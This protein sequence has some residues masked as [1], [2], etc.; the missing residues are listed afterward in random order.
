[1][2]LCGLV[3]ESRRRALEMVFPS[4]LLST[5][6]PVCR[7]ILRRCMISLFQVSQCTESNSCGSYHYCNHCWNGTV[8][9]YTY[10]A[11]REEFR[12]SIPRRSREESMVGGQSTYIPSKGKHRWCYPGYLC[13]SHC[14]RRRLSLHSLL[15]KGNG[16]GIGSKIL[17][18]MI[19]VKLV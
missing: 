8:C 16:T 14:C 6:S 18:G 7:M 2:F 3:R 9:C 10:R 13:I 12:F 17:R 5:L 4:Y 11:A 1:M 19:T 15:G